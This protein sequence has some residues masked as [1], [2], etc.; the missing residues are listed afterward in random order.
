MC[1]CGD[2]E[3]CNERAVMGYHGFTVC[4]LC[5]KDI[6]NIDYHECVTKAKPKPKSSLVFTQ[7]HPLKCQMH[8]KPMYLMRVDWVN[9]QG[10]ALQKKDKQIVTV[11]CGDGCKS[12]F[13]CSKI[14]YGR[15]AFDFKVEL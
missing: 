14:E 4:P 13:K 8:N 3:E 6:S 5:D 9:D 12:E 1:R 2:C 15:G 7:E 11:Q 10:C